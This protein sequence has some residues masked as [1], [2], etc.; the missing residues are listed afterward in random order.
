MTT[1]KQKAALF[2]IRQLF[3]WIKR[4]WHRAIVAGGNPPTIVA[5][6]VFHL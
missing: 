4:T 3:G 2:K 6:A 1:P 5:A